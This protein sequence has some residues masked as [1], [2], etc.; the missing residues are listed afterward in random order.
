MLSLPTTTTT[1]QP[2]DTFMM[3]TSSSSR[4]V[5]EPLALAWNS[6]GKNVYAAAA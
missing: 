2:G 6:Y 5:K 3:I 4:S 1:N